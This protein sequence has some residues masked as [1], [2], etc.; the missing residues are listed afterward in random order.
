MTAQQKE[1]VCQHSESLVGYL[2]TCRHCR[3]IR[4]YDPDS[5][6]PPRVLR[7]GRDPVAGALT[8]VNPPPRIPG[9]KEDRRVA[10]ALTQEDLG[11]VGTKLDRRNQGMTGIRQLYPL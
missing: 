7:R 1:V 6:R 5:N 8:M 10:E 2:G 4:K 11:L 9:T 3:Q